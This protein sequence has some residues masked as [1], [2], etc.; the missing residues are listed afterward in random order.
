MVDG[1]LYPPTKFGDSSAITDKKN[2][3]GRYMWACHKKFLCTPVTDVTTNVHTKFGDS[4]FFRGVW[5]CSVVW[6]RGIQCFDAK[7]C[8]MSVST[9]MSILVAIASKL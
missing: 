1:T 6:G 2:R 9:F 5:P 8:Q 7:L 4:G 3:G